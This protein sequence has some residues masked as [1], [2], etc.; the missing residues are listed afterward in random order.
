MT[1]STPSATDHRY[2]LPRSN[3]SLWRWVC[4]R[5]AGFPADRVHAL[6]SPALAGAVD[7]LL[8]LDADREAARGSAVAI[9]EADLES[10]TDSRERRAIAPYLRKLR[11]G[12]VPAVDDNATLSE[13]SRSALYALHAAELAFQDQRAGAEQVQLA[14]R[15]RLARVLRDAAQDPRYRE[16]LVWQNRRVLHDGVDVFL[17]QPE[18]KSSSKMR[19]FERLIANH[20]Q[21]YCLKNESIGFF[22]PVGWGRIAGDAPITARP[23]PELLAER[24]VHFEHWAIDALAS[25]ILTDEL[26]QYLVPRRRPII[27]LDG[28]TLHHPV[29][30]TTELPPDFARVLAA[31]DGVRSARE[32]VAAL[33][34]DPE[35]GLAED[36]VYELLESLD[37]QRLVLW[38]IEL[39]PYAEQHDRVLSSILDAIPDPDVAAAPLDALAE[40]RAARDRVAHAAGDPVALDAAFANIEDTFA[41]L[42][43][44]DATRRHGE[45]YAGRTV[46]YEDCR[47]DID[48]TFGPGVVDRLASPLS[49]VLTSARWYTFTIAQRYRET[50]VS[51]HREMQ[52]ET[53]ATSIDF[54]R[55][56]E[57]ASDFFGAQSGKAPVLIEG[58]NTELHQ[59]W[60]TILGL[61]GPAFEQHR[62]ELAS[63]DI[64]GAVA[65]AFAAP[66]PGWPS[67]RHHSPDLMISARSVD[68]IARGELALVAGELHIACSTIAVPWTVRLHPQREDIVEALRRDRPNPTIEGLAVKERTTRSAR[69]S[70]SPDDY[71]LEL[72][73]ARSRR[74]R[75][76]V[77]E[78]GALRV[79]PDGDSLRV[80]T[81]DRTRSFAIEE[82]LDGFLTNECVGFRLLAKA[83]H[84]PRISID[85]FV[86][87][88]ESWL[89]RTE[90]LAFAQIADPIDRMIAARRWARAHDLPRFVFYKV[91]QEKKPCFLDLESPHYIDLMSHLVRKAPE[92]GVSEMLPDVDHVW[93]PGRDGARYT[94]ELRICAVDPEP[95]RR[96]V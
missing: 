33:T 13:H 43:G 51:L 5:G 34:A 66:C 27:W 54:L 39:P 21:R 30:Q 36:D 42:T 17:R 61:V 35:L 10:R 32:I 2:L 18:G 50:F 76:Q 84:L 95:W 12:S 57:R 75:P 25:S 44:A 83:P 82:F 81:R 80:V 94:S 24:F 96:I 6:A 78:A 19:Q 68:A 60:A 47:R 28:T 8:A 37:E 63:A 7:R 23:G 53:G 69:F 40:L 73:T 16:A 91:P 74:P 67:A 70:I 20:I 45:T 79:E 93:L 11:A 38:T 29:D 22:G 41:R 89:F 58:V 86:I 85:D 14:E 71:D 55:F 56:W 65:T 59:R 90:D 48:I 1:A 77:L 9:V 72:G 49:L 31:C 64:A 87:G 62:L 3:W 52:R 92:V 88:R 4:V 15:D 46:L 26:R